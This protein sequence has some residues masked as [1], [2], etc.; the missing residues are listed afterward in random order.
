MSGCSIKYT[1]LGGLQPDDL[2][3]GLLEFDGC[4]ILLDCGWDESFSLEAVQHLRDIAPQVDAVLLSHQ[5]LQHVGAL[6]YLIAHCGLS[7]P[8]LGTLPVQR[9]G[10]L[11]LQELVSAKKASSDF[12]LFEVGDVVDAFSSNRWTLLRY[13]QQ[14]LLPGAGPDQAIQVTPYN[15]GRLVGGAV[16]RLVSQSGEEVVYA[17]D[18]CHRRERHLAACSLADLFTQRPALLIADAMDGLAP[19][20]DSS[21]RDVEFLDCVLAT[22][23]GADGS[24][25]LPTDCAGRALELALLL[26]EFWAREKYDRVY[27]LVWVSETC[28]AVADA[29]QSQLEWMA[30]SVGKA[31]EMH[32]N[33]PFN[34]RCL[35]LLPSPSHLAQLQ[36]GP[37]VVL[38][39]F[40]SLELGAARELLLQWLGG[41]SN[42]VC[43]VQRPPG[44]TLGDQLL[45]HSPRPG[46]PPLR[47]SLLTSRRIPLEGE[48]LEAWE[49]GRAAVELAGLAARAQGQRGRQEGEGEPL[50]G[51]GALDVPVRLPGAGGSGLLQQGPGLL[52]LRASTPHISTLV[53]DAGSGLWMQ[54]LQQAQ[55]GEQDQQ[56]APPGGLPPQ[57]LLGA[58]SSGGGP[59]ALAEV[60]LD[61]FVPPTGSAYPMFPDEAEAL[62]GEQWDE[63][64]VLPDLE[65]LKAAQRATGGLLGFIP[66][67]H[68]GLAGR[69][70]L[71]GGL[72]GRQLR[73]GHRGH[74]ARVKGDVKAEG[75]EVDEKEEDGLQAEREQEAP[76]EAQ[77]EEEEE[78]EGAQDDRPTK[79]VCEK[80]EVEVCAAVRFFNYEGRADA[81]IV[82]KVLC[83]VAPRSLL[84]L[85]GTPLARAELLL[86][87]GKELTSL[88]CKLL[89]PECCEEA[90]ASVPP[91]A[92]LVVSDALHALSGPRRLA[93][94]NYA[95]SLMDAV[96]AP[97][98]PHF[99]GLQQLVP[100]PP[101]AMEEDEE[102]GA[103]Q[104][105]SSGVPE[106]QQWVGDVFFAQGAEGIMLSSVKKALADSGIQSAWLGPGALSCGPVIISKA[107]VYAS[108]LSGARG[109]APGVT[110]YH[111]LDDA[112]STTGKGHLILEGAMSEQHEDL[113]Q[114]I[115]AVIY[116][117]FSAASA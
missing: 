4:K 61:G 99:S 117:Q 92:S 109:L 112:A 51:L 22:L 98:G 55:P 2:V 81:R 84:L 42:T 24:V 71:R 86:H 8:I 116:T 32:R 49:Q 12:S 33:N 115:R 103:R 53:K 110:S 114:R 11:A 50:P 90:D 27:P 52:P 34:F 30:D 72:E 38:A 37:K 105:R 97:P 20:V 83:D 70:A 39:S 6:P 21:R 106:E 58:A 62:L 113:M 100:A 13:Y 74:M 7:A 45:R 59:L 56:V 95:V 94:S 46:Q 67:L 18:W 80:V 16:W 19:S 75:M 3:A 107:S 9:M 77:G 88:G 93:A 41:P 69:L 54:Q 60:L 64:G 10:S 79:L 29:A 101:P 25:L 15:S 89:V 104:G 43:F 5:D 14:Y 102:S 28:R 111:T 63:Y 66:G 31:F 48:E 47:L 73:G 85:R 35:K 57:A 76:A 1:P 40:P 87:L 108:A 26:D 78:E 44:G 96:V 68:G 91:S 23:R 82:R 17:V 36:S 65:G